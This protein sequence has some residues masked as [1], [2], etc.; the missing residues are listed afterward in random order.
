M[1]HSFQALVSVSQVHPRKK[2]GKTKFQS[3]TT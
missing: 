1:Q 2:V 3:S